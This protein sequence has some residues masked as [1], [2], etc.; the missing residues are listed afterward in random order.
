MDSFGLKTLSISS[1]SLSLSLSLSFPDDAPSK[2]LTV[3][4]T[5]SRVRRSKLS[6]QVGGTRVG[7]K[8]F[9]LDLANSPHTATGF[10][11]LFVA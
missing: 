8:G 1:I 10:T 5:S 4:F 6:R 3:Q 7:G 9:D 11:A 2:D